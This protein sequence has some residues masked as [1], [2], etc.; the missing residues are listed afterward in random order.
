[1][2]SRKYIFC[3][4]SLELESEESILP[5]GE[6]SKFLSEFSNADDKIRVI[7]TDSLPPE[8]G[9]LLFSSNRK[10]I[11]YDGKEKLILHISIVSFVN[12]LILHAR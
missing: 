5:E 11:Y 6:F 3:G 10:K 9:E 4:Y 2:Q 1:M 8:N 7:R 12:M